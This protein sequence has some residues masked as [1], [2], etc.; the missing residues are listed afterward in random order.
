MRS[1]PGGG[2][3]VS[4]VMTTRGEMRAPV[5][6]QATKTPAGL[7]GWIETRLIIT[8]STF[9]SRVSERLCL[10]IPADPE[11]TAADDPNASLFAP[12]GGPC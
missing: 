4:A 7:L 1:P 3:F 11:K 10:F 12:C 9:R 5:S 2:W 8:A 6:D